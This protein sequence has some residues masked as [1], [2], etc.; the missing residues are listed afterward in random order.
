M[1]NFS[2]LIND[3]CRR[4]TFALSRDLLDPTVSPVT[5]SFPPSETQLSALT[6]DYLTEAFLTRLRFLHTQ[7]T[8]LALKDLFAVGWP[9]P[10]RSLQQKTKYLLSAWKWNKSLKKQAKIAKNDTLLKYSQELDDKIRHEILADHHVDFAKQVQG[11]QFNLQDY[12]QKNLRQTQNT[13]LDQLKILIKTPWNQLDS[14]KL[15]QTAKKVESHLPAI[16]LHMLQIKPSK[17]NY[18]WNK[19]TGFFANWFGKKGVYQEKISHYSQWVECEKILKYHLGR[20]KQ[21][22]V[23]HVVRR[24]EFEEMKPVIHEKIAG[25]SEEKSSILESKEVGIQQLKPPAKKPY[26]ASLH[27]IPTVKDNIT[28]PRASYRMKSGNIIKH[29]SNTSEDKEGRQGAWAELVRTIKQAEHVIFIAGWLFEPQYYFPNKISQTKT[30]GELLLERAI[31]YPKIEIAIL[32]WRQFASSKQ[33][34]NALD[35][36]KQLAIAKG[37]KGLPP[38]IQLR[39]VRRTGVAWSHH[40]K[41]VVADTRMDGHAS[42]RELTAFYGSADLA[43][44]KFDWHEHPILDTPDNHDL[45]T[46]VF[47][48][49]G[50]YRGASVEFNQNTP[51]LPWRE[52]MSQIRG[53]VAR[54]MMTEFVKRWCGDNEGAFSQYSGSLDLEQRVLFRYADI[55]Q[56]HLFDYEISP[57]RSEHKPIWDAQLVRS[58]QSSVY[59][60]RWQL[61]QKHEK[62]IHKAYLQAIHQAESFIYMETQYITGAGP[63]Q[64]K[65]RLPQAIVDRIVEQH[66]LGKPFH[67]FIMLPI[68]PNGDAGGKVHVEPV[69]Y[70][71]WQTMRWMM[72][73][74][75]ARTGVFWG[76]YLS[77]NFF[78]Q[79]LKRH[80]NYLEKFNNPKTTYPELV[81]YSGHAAVYI[82]SKLMIVD[83]KIVING[84]ANLTERSLAGPYDTEIGIYQRPT[85]GCEAACIEETRA[86]RRQI[87]TDYFGRN[88]MKALDEKGFAHPETLEHVSIIRKRALVNLNNFMTGKKAA[89][90][91]SGH[92]LTWPFKFKKGCI[93]EIEAGHEYLPDTLLKNIK[94]GSTTFKWFPS[95]ESKPIALNIANGL[96][97]KGYR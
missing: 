45:V 56:N 34:K 53:P 78:G 11:L 97:H 27:G 10:L 64:S 85:P 63:N 46:T 33:H 69:R 3:L 42:A 88:C 36:L 66:K 65:N 61:K 2:D 83:D 90:A 86:L 71:Q 80:H 9:Q 40:Q 17:A 31:A 89:D 41:F 5:F 81:T 70:L 32:V 67:V 92:L 4:A 72:Q 73:E 55:C 1:P 47:R 26:Y 84:S 74:I 8:A 43:G 25:L 22:P 6:G 87:W 19:F 37:L 24:D 29:F 91:D 30:L 52:V 48:D 75:E 13:P 96:R 60:G 23:Y 79:W 49:T 95:L 18:F 54:D 68:L 59:A 21:H 28:H 57:S 77:F 35:Y 76:N 14:F 38:N 16:Q 82:H 20:I 94:N 12:L 62:S 58:A 51:R 44:G 93:G 50:I 15:K 7:S 39:Q